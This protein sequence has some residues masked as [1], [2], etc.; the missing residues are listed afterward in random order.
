MKK[1]IVFILFMLIILQTVVFA[2]VSQESTEVLRNPDR[3]FY[4]LIEIDLQ[5]GEENFEDFREE[6]EWI[7]EDDPDVSLIEFQLCLKNF[8]SEPNDITS[9]KIADINNYFSI[10]REFGYQVIYRVVYDSEGEPNP[11]PEFSDILK[12]ISQMKNVYET[13]EDILFVIEAGYIGSWGEWHS[14]KYDEDKQYRNQVIDK[15]LECVPE[16]VQINLRRPSFIIDYM[17]N[18]QTVNENNAYT[19]EKIARLGLHNDGYLASITDLGTFLSSERDEIMK[20]QEKQTEYTLFGGESQ[21]KESTYNDLN[22][23]ILDM[24]LRHCTYLNKAYDREVKTKWKNSIYNGEDVLYNGLDGYTY[25]QNHLGYRLV[26]KESKID[27][28]AGKLKVNL[29]IEN[30]GFGNIVREK[31]VELILKSDTDIYYI[32]TDIDIRKC[33]NN[34]N[35]IIEIQENLPTDFKENKYTVFLNICEPFDTLK[36]NKNY[37]IKLANTDIWNDEIGANHIGQAKY[38]MDSILNM[39]KLVIIIII[40]AIVIIA[41]R[42]L[43]RKN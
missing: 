42:F 12:H 32:S 10:L 20:W 27:I 3:G 7:M 24:K 13:N 1:S 29:D 6:V 30:V 23:A 38:E 28:K 8:V 35:Y 21:N 34:T 25:I 33:L 16:S 4:K 17:G 43:T 41:I 31:K 2:K 11:E 15:L 19:N 9:K 40:V 26:L 36:E 39:G 5:Q 18:Y 14:G 22:N 37:R